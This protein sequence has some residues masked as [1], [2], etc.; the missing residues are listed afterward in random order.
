[1]A[2]TYT[3]KQVA[4]ILG[5]STN[6]IYTFLKEKRIT[7]V[8]VGT[9]RFRIPQSELDRLLLTSKKQTIDETSQPEIALANAS[10]SPIHGQG[11]TDVSGGAL[12][13]DIK[14]LGLVH[15]GTVN[16]FDWFIGTGAIVAGLGLFLYNSS[17]SFFPMGINSPV[18][19]AVR[20]I[21]IGCGI[22]ILLTNITGQTHLFWHKLF[23]II[24]GVLG[25]AMTVGFW[26]GGDVDGAMI[27]AP[28]SILVLLS[29]FIHIGGVAWVSLYI[30]LLTVGTNITIL[31][32]ARN[33][34]VL[35]LLQVSPFHG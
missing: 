33:P 34:H 3:V 15:V 30:S 21:L 6:S 20:A 12:I 19:T 29:S 1:M 23:H 32:A 18:L 24:L 13:D 5:Y 14:L 17:F 26:M 2:A 22:G 11:V 35:S 28:V 9:G 27:Y 16:I 25:I 4:N 31:L 10:F 7:G 8:R